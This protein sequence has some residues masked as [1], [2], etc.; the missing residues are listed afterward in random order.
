ME[1]IRRLSRLRSTARRRIVRLWTPLILMAIAGCTSG[2]STTPAV[3]DHSIPIVAGEVVLAIGPAQGITERTQRSNGW[4]GHFVTC[5]NTSPRSVWI[6]ESYPVLAIETRAN[7]TAEWHSHQFLY[8]GGTR[9]LEL[10]P[11]DSHSFTAAV[12]EEFVGQQFRIMLVYYTVPGGPYGAMR[13]ASGAHELERPT[14][15]ENG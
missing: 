1:S 15:K 14:A 2:N 8:C 10:A 11:G 5:T 3:G 12:P 7:E 9:Y 13:A 4:I 6:A